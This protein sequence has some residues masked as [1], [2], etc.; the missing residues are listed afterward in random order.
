M[1]PS[2][3]GGRPCWVCIIGGTTLIALAVGVVVALFV[4]LL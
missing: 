2:S 4:Y 3:S 1:T